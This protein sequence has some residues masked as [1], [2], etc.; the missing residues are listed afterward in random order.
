[1]GAAAARMALQAAGVS[2]RELDVIVSVGS[3]PYQPIPCTAAFLQRALLLDDSGIAAFDVNSTCLGFIVALDLVAQALATGRYGKALIVAS[4]PASLGLDWDDA[5]TAGLFGD[6]AGAVV[7]GAPRRSGAGLRASHV[8]TYSS[9]LDFCQIRAGGTS[10]YPRA[11]HVGSLDG[12]AFEMKGRLAYR[13]AAERLPQFLDRLLSAAGIGKSDVDV[14][15]PHQASGHAITHLQ[16]VLELPLERM[17]VTLETVGNQVSASLPI[18]L[19]RG[20]TSGR[21]RE[22]SLVALVGAG[23]GMSFGGTVLDY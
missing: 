22:G 20:V 1:M 17:I 12:T 3:V 13:L 23:A 5:S 10:R 14:W 9:G 16:A 21:I 18:A 7:V 15:V 4:E 2:A 6:G 8:A 11:G 19:H